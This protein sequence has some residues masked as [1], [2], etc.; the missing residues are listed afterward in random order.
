MEQTD[1]ATVNIIIIILIKNKL[2][3]CS[4][5]STKLLLLLFIY[6]LKIYT[7]ASVK[8]HR[9]IHGRRGSLMVSMS[10]CHAV[11]RRLVPRTRRMALLGVKTWLS[12]LES[13]L[14]ISVFRMRH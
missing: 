2:Q 14:C 4:S 1:S 8:G 3:P 10:T 9:E 7:H 6:I 12:I 11:G 5:T 13:R